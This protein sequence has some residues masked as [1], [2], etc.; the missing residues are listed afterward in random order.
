MSC[1]ETSWSKG[2]ATRTADE[3]LCWLRM[4]E[5]PFHSTAVP[6]EL[7]YVSHEHWLLSR[8]K[9]TET[10]QPPEQKNPSKPGGEEDWRP[11]DLGSRVL[12]SSQRQR[13]GSHNISAAAPAAGTCAFL[14]IRN[15]H[16]DLK[17]R[18]QT[19]SYLRCTVRLGL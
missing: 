5:K 19:G 7:V 3:C 12:I 13:R 17:I 2:A 4:R 15:W 9:P 16:S 14:R 11:A 6:E 1:E 8:V 18:L 10:K